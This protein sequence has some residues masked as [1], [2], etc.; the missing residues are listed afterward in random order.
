MADISKYLT[1][2]EAAEL[3]GILRTT[4]L[5]AA[6]EARKEIITG[7]TAG[8]TVLVLKSSL[9][10]WAKNRPKPGPKPKE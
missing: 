6:S 7:T 4:I 8:G 1:P 3:T 9:E 2:T 5:W 10:K